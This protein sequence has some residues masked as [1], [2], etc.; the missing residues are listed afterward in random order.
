MS[1]MPAPLVRKKLIEVAL[2]LDEINAAGAREKSIRH[3]HPSTLHL[4]WSRKPL[5]VARAVIFSQLVDDPSEY[6]DV[7][8]SDSATKRAAQRAL[9]QRRSSDDDVQASAA[10]DLQALREIAAEQ[11]RERLFRILETKGDTGTASTGWE[12][13]LDAVIRSGF[14]ITGTWP[15]R[16]ENTTRLVGMGTN[17][18]ASSIILVCRRRLAEA[19][20]AT[21]REFLTALRSELPLA[22]RLLQ[23][24]NVAP[25]DLAQAAIGPG[26]GVYTRYARSD[27]HLQGGCLS[28]LAGDQ[29]HPRIGRRCSPA[30]RKTGPTGDQHE[31]ISRRVGGGSAANENPG[32]E[33]VARRGV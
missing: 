16:T 33:P 27:H 3:G 30:G 26:M 21:R 14:A 15:M 23:S 10:D 31:R 17:A 8:L 1:S 24:G 22:L 11:E 2:P 32:Q 13:F 7:L 9:R 19:P 12:T 18:L 5:A 6:V 29:R 20:A 4:W 28:R 25:V